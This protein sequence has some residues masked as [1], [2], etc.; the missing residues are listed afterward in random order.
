MQMDTLTCCR[1]ASASAAATR[2]L[3]ALRSRYFLLGRSAAE[4]VIASANTAIVSLT[5]D[6]SNV[7]RLN[8]AK[9][10]MERN[11]STLDGVCQTRVNRRNA[12]TTSTFAWQLLVR[13]SWTGDRFHAQD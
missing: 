8:V 2:V 13:A 6:G 10:N 3:T 11:A 5:R 9:L 7:A 12:P 1:S 4:A